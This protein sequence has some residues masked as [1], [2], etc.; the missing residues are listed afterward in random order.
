MS[1]Y[2]WWIGG[3]VNHR[4]YYPD[5]DFYSTSII[6]NFRGKHLAFGMSCDTITSDNCNKEEDKLIGNHIL[7]CNFYYNKH[8]KMSSLHK[9][10]TAEGS[11]YENIR[12][13]RRRKTPF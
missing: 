7:T 11:T 6:G 10:C 3:G 1:K 12:K 13:E 4:G 8:K 5:W 9:M 2:L